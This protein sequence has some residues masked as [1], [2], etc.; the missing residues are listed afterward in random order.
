MAA[1]G[2][3]LYWQTTTVN[4]MNN[5][6]YRRHPTYHWRRQ[7]IQLI[8]NSSIIATRDLRISID[9]VGSLDNWHLFYNPAVFC[10]LMK[11]R[12]CYDAKVMT[13]L[14]CLTKQSF[15]PGNELF[16]DKKKEEIMLII[17]CSINKQSATNRLLVASKT[18]YAQYNVHP[19][20][21]RCVLHFQ[22][23]SRFSWTFP[24]V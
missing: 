4:K 13:Y 3:C 7:T 23:S 6:T 18:N 15:K 16:C 5:S 10:T 2:C 21:Q 24:C 17:L 9:N 11:W 8:L 20:K 19:L 12:H 14:L 1:L 22:W